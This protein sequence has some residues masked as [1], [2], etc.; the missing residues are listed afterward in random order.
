MY[1]GGETMKDIRVK[2][3][4]RGVRTMA[5]NPLTVGAIERMLRN[6]RYIGEYRQKEVV[7]CDAIPPIVSHEL[8]DSVQNKLAKNVKSAARFKAK[9]EMY[10]LST[11]LFCGDC[12][13]FMVGESGTSGTNGKIHRYYK[14]GNA[15]RNKGCKRKAIRK[16]WI[17]NI[18]IGY[19]MKSLNV[20]AIIEDIANA[21]VAALGEGNI[22]LP[23]LEKQLADVERNVENMLNAIQEGIFTPSTKQR[24]EDLEAKREII[25]G[26]I[27]REEIIQTRLT[28]EEITFWLH[29]FRKLD[30][31]E[32]EQRQRLVD[33][34]LNAVYVYNDRILL[35]INGEEG[36][37]TLTLSEIQSSDMSSLAPPTDSVLSF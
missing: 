3:S 2:L 37:E 11:K 18:V 28:K 34:F 22:V 29:R 31:T 8:F 15:K 1:D 13:V 6:R 16:G 7:N 5:G 33:V 14:C 36:A 12:G 24:L 26:D 17:E 20:D 35:V 4:R 19:I 21:I 25:K 10:L 32:Y 27:A 30:T 23:L 9:E